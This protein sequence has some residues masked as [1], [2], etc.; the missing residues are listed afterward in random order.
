[1]TYVL[2]DDVL[3]AGDPWLQAPHLKTLRDGLRLEVGPNVWVCESWLVERGFRLRGRMRAGL[4]ASDLSR[5]LGRAAEA[6]MERQKEATL[7]VLRTRLGAQLAPAPDMERLLS[8]GESDPFVLDDTGAWGVACELASAGQRTLLLTDDP[9]RY[10]EVA[11]RFADR[12]WPQPEVVGPLLPFMREELHRLPQLSDAFLLEAVEQEETGEDEVR[13]VVCEAIDSDGQKALGRLVSRHDSYL[14]GGFH[15]GDPAVGFV[16]VDQREDG[17]VVVAVVFVTEID[18]E[19]VAEAAVADNG[20]YAWAMDTE[21]TRWGLVEAH[22]H[23]DFRLEG[24]VLK[25]RRMGGA[26]FDVVG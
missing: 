18:V 4:H 13:R 23:V 12:S 9:A 7:S 6:H 19:L 14:L 16:D 22:V 1:M 20:R 15:V 11:Q 10:A 17:S 21:S 2:I 3:L 25:L 5:P 8:L 24:G 26:S